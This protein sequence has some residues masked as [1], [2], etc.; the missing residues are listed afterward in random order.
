MRQHY[1]HLPQAS[2]WDQPALWAALRKRRVERVALYTIDAQNATGHRL[3][4]EWNGDSKDANACQLLVDQIRECFHQAA[5]DLDFAVK[6]TPEAESQQ[7]F[8]S[9][10]LLISP[11][12]SSFS[13]FAGLAD[14]AKYYTAAFVDER[15]RGQDGGGGV[16]VPGLARAVP[17]HMQPGPP[18]WHADVFDYHADVAAHRFV[19]QHCARAPPPRGPPE[20]G[21]RPPPR[22]AQMHA[23]PP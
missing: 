11:V 7:A 5:P 10:R 19:P 20:S 15:D 9:A 6:R 17:W 12:P 13:F 16:D 1:Y 23:P 21:P 14:P 2:F 3:S 18:V 22:H 8:L 4:A